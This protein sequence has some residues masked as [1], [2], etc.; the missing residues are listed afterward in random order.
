MFSWF[1]K[2]NRDIDLTSI[3]SYWEGEYGL[4]NETNF[5][6]VFVKQNSQKHSTFSFYQSL[7]ATQSSRQVFASE[8]DSQL[9][10]FLFDW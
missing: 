1:V 2:K 5:K 10:S 7:L 9:L 3:D 6:P 4:S 8:N